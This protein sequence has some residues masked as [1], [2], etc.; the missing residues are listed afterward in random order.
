MSRDLFQSS[1]L[2]RLCGTESAVSIEYMRESV[3]RD[4]ENL[5]N[6]FQGRNDIPSYFTEV[7][8]S[9]ALY[10][11]NNFNN[12]NL[13]AF[14]ERQRLLMSIQ[15]AISLFEPRLEQVRVDDEGVVD[16]FILKFKI[17]GILRVGKYTDTVVFGTEIHKYGAAVVQS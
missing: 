3:R 13:E 9:L 6:A 8:R 11:L 17:S 1:I 16:H 5:L 12:A 7:H 14:E 10:G 4:L 2:D 15:R